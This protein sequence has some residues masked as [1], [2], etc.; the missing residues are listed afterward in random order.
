MPDRFIR[1]LFFSTLTLLLGLSCNSD[2][3]EIRDT[4]YTLNENT[5]I[6]FR[7]QLEYTSA[8]NPYTYRNFYNGAGVAVGDINND[9]LDDIYFTGNLVDNQLY[10]N[11]GN[12]KFKNIS[13]SAGVTCSDIWSSG[14]VFVD[15]NADG[16]LDIY[17]CK[18]GPPN[19]KNRHNE[20]FI[21]NGDL[22]FTESSEAYGLDIIGLGIQSAFFDYDRDGDLDCYLLNNSIRAIGGFDLIKDKRDEHNKDGNKLL[23]NDDGVYKD[24]TQESGIY[25]SEIGFGLGITVSDFN[26]DGWPDL[27]ISNDFFEKDYLYINQ[28]NGLFQ[29]QGEEYFECFSLGSMGADAADLNNDLLPDLMV[30]EM[31]PST[32]E[33]KKTKAVYDNWNKYHRS[34]K[35]GYSHQVPRNTLQ[36]NVDGHQFLE[37]GRHAHV[38]DTDWSWSCLMQDYNNDGYKDIFI[39]NGIYK[40]LLDRDYLDFAGN[41]AASQL[42]MK[43]KEK[44]VKQ[45]IDTMSSEAIPN[46]MFSHSGDFNYVNVSKNWGL[47]MPSFSNGSA[48]ADLDNDGD[49]DLIINNVNQDASI[50]INKEREQSNNNYIQFVIKGEAKNPFG[51]G[52]KII[53]YAC[54]KTMM[55]ELYPSRGFQSS[56][57]YKLHFGLGQCTIV[58]SI[59]IISPNGSTDI[60]T[61]LKT[62]ET[63]TITLSASPNLSDITINKTPILLLVDSIDYQHAQPY[64][65]QFNR[66][67]LMYKMNTEKGPAIITGDVDSDGDD[68]I[69]IG[70]AKNQSS[71][72]YINNNG[73]YEG[74]TTYFESKQKSEVTDAI[75][76]DSDNDGDLDMYV[77]HGG[78]AFSRYAPELHDAIYLNDGQGSYK[79]SHNSIKF[80]SPI[81][82]S[83]VSIIDVDNDGYQ[84][85]FLGSNNSNLSYGTPGSAYIF[86]NNGDNTFSDLSI[87]ALKNIGIITDSAITDINGDSRTDII[88]TGEWMPVTVLISKDNSLVIDDKNYGFNKSSG[89]WNN[90]LMHDLNK[91]GKEDILIG[92]VGSNSAISDRNKLYIGDFDNNGSA[93][94]ILCETVEGVDYPIID[95]DLLRSQLP[96]VKKK[97]LRHQQYAESDMTSLFGQDIVDNASVLS[98]DDTE[99]ALYISSDDGYIKSTLPQQIQYSST[100]IAIATDIDKDGNDDILMGGNHHLILPQYGREDAST[101]WLLYGEKSNTGYRI[102]TAESLSIKGEIRDI[103]LIN[104]DKY[105][106]GVND[107]STYIY[108]SNNIKSN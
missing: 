103:E 23:R 27:Y 61:N 12:L 52:T 34:V 64:F 78:T 13:Q 86:K 28:Q 76:F 2:V 5:G 18:A 77:A 26:L 74:V 49:L 108:T 9:G 32:I 4:L 96:A 40:D 59:K 37:I 91:D 19:G 106:F 38:E 56:V 29:E 65:N 90:I 42:I 95:F 6:T 101:G 53:L 92:N 10:L 41:E 62:N 31:Y 81:A 11:E 80:E 63:Q 8:L 105:I 25:S 45:L 60:V 54:D 20:L 55:N 73:K 36:Y 14:A 51:I 24:V 89:L 97:V 75:F 88:I 43:Y 82:T 39:S 84:D 50:Y 33:R 57:S 71:T 30:T 102:D 68:D 93:E 3:V 107:Q 72:L 16:Y 98:I 58:D 47:D 94:Q 15:I 69:F 99:T 17:V 85:I 67:P 100:H 70:G 22:T 87:E 46:A 44:G 104:K 21:N 83:T 35:A 66:E 79:L 7:N 1:L 48:Y